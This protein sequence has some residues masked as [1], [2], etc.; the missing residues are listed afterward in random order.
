[1][2]VMSIEMLNDPIGVSR[3][4]YLMPKSTPSVFRLPRLKIG[5]WNTWNLA[6]V[7]AGP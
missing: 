5:C 6:G 1:M 7:R 4:A 3:S 2:W